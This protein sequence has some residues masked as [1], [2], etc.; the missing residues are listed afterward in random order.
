C[1]RRSRTNTSLQSLGLLNEVQRVELSRML[2]ERLLREADNETKRLDL[3]FKLLAS[4]KPT[5]RER[6]VC[7]KLLQSLKERYATAENDALALLSTGDAPRD[8]KLNPGEL[9]AWSQLAITVLA[10]DVALLLY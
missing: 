9:A 3:L 2:A 1:V 8:E 4:R 10:S 6:A 5:A 7:T